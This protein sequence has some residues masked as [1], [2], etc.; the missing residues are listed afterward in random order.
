LA[1]VDFAVV[2]FLDSAI[3]DFLASAGLGFFDSALVAV[4]GGPGIPVALLRPVLTEDAAAAAVD[5]FC[6]F[7][8]WDFVLKVVGCGGI[9]VTN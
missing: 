7:E 9:G 4:A 8:F 5:F 6:N 3:F 2:G 1:L